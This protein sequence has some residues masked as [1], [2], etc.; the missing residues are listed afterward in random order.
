MG[1]HILHSVNFSLPLRQIP[2]YDEPQL[3]SCE[4]EPAFFRVG[5]SHG[6]KLDEHTVATRSRG[7]LA[8]TGP[9]SG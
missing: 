5:N 9:Y 4:K 8:G 7:Q 6:I 2:P 3:V 1:A